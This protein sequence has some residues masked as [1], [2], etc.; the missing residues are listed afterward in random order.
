M[1]GS[2]P[3]SEQL[4]VFR[5]TKQGHRKIVIATNIAETSVTIPGIVYGK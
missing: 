4:D 5:F 3:S 2:L 1:Y